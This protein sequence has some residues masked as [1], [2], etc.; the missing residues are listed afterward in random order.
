[1]KAQPLLFLGERR[2]TAL[3]SRTATA[4]GRWRQAWAPG[5]GDSF[6]TSSESPGAGGFKELV[7]SVATS[8]WELCVGGERVAVLLLPHSTFAWCVHNGG[9]QPLDGA[10]PVAADSIGEQLESEVARSL[11]TEACTVDKREVAN[12]ARV[13]SSDLA[14]WSRTA[15]AW[16]LQA[17]AA[18]GRSLTL[19]VA[20]SR[21]EVLLPARAPGMQPLQSAREAIGENTLS[22]RAVVGETR[23]PVGELAELAIDDVLVL[24]Q[25]LTDPVTVI[26]GKSQTSVVAGNLGRAGARRAI[27]ITGALTPRN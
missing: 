21:I 20:A 5:A 4:L 7:A 3:E 9:G 11:L 2:R 18:A 26:C 15:R 16:K 22:L 12:V 1:M 27:K 17:R 24:D 8:G 13:A 25:V 6:E 19:L 14:E 10:M 23:I